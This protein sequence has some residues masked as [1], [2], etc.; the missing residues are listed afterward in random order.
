MNRFPHTTSLKVSRDGVHANDLDDAYLPLKALA[1]YSGLSVRTLRGHLLDPIRPV[2]HF[3][4]GGKI[5]VRRREFDG[6]VQ[7]FRVT[8]PTGIDAIVDDVLA[9]LR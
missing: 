9:N 6:W 4:I 3:R 1:A 2:P 8:S 5:L 7:Q